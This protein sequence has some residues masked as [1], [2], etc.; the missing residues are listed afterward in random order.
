MDTMSCQPLARRVMKSIVVDHNKQKMRLFCIKTVYRNRLSRSKYWILSHGYYATEDPTPTDETFN[1]KL[2]QYLCL[3][4]SGRVLNCS[5][6]L[7]FRLIRG[8][9]R[10]T[11]R[12]QDQKR[13]KAQGECEVL[14][15]KPVNADQILTNTKKNWIIKINSTIQYE[16]MTFRLFVWRQFCQNKS[17]AKWTKNRRHQAD[18]R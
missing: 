17:G 10:W 14:G 11:T 1:C 9:V 3:L 7:I 13:R 18:L 8:K 6:R 4:M 15:N 12:F 2:N 16:E 5:R